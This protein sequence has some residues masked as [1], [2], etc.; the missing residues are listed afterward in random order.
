MGLGSGFCDEERERCWVRKR[1]FFF[2]FLRMGREKDV[3]RK[4]G[5]K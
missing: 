3:G 5:D 4:R 2:F 1:C